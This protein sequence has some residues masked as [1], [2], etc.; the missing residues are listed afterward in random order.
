M[1]GTEQ[2]SHEG[3]V[4]NRIGDKAII[5]LIKPEEC[6]SCRMKEFCG[7]TDEDRSRFEVPVE[8]LEIGDTIALEV[9]PGI[10]FKALFWAYIIPFLLVVLVIAIGSW[11]GLPEQ[12]LG[13]FSL[14]ILP[15]YFFALSRFKHQLKSQLNLKVSKL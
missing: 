11:S 8:D 1:T 10:G 12:W 15:P 7:V 5:H 3:I 14:L 13:V 6:H 4:T 2:I 9:K